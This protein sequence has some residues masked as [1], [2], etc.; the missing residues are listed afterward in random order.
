MANA[1]LIKLG[2]LSLIRVK[3]RLISLPTELQRKVIDTDERLKLCLLVEDGTTEIDDVLV[4]LPRSNPEINYQFI[5]KSGPAR[6]LRTPG[7]WNFAGI[8]KE[9]LIEA[10]GL[11]NF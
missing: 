1:F 2:R 4:W 3:G 7:R 6:R 8:F 5:H 11:G 9:I 10:P